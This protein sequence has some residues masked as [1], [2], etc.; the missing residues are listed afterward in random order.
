MCLVCVE[1]APS[2][3][4][5]HA[6]AGADWFVVVVS[7]LIVSLAG[8]QTAAWP[9]LRLPV[10]HW[11]CHGICALMI[12]ASCFFVASC[13]Y[14]QLQNSVLDFF[15]NLGLLD[16]FSQLFWWHIPREILYKCLV[17]IYRLTVS[18]LPHDI[19]MPWSLKCYRLQWC[20]A[21]EMK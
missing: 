2:D 13:I 12:R 10:W 5:L 17:N 21:G 6:E 7:S 15:H 3:D 1:Q 4:V 20:L 8:V 16:W 9:D 14:C 19:V 11:L 18:I